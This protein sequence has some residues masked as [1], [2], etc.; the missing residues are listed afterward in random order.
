MKTI[1]K[2]AWYKCNVF[3]KS[4]CFYLFAYDVVEIVILGTNLAFVSADK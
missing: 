3:V 2:Q 1:G 4:N